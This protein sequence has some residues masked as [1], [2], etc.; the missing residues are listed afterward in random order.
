M[1][2]GTLSPEEVARLKEARGYDIRI[3]E[4]A[5]RRRMAPATGSASRAPDSVKPPHYLPALGHHAQVLEHINPYA[6]AAIASKEG[7]LPPD[8]PSRRPS[9]SEAPELKKPKLEPDEDMPENP[10]TPGH[11]ISGST[12]V[13]SVDADVDIPALEQAASPSFASQAKDVP[14]VAGFGRLTTPQQVF[15]LVIGCRGQG[16]P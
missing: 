5:E 11:A 10:V 1:S 3:E 7:A 2:K 13:D 14:E 15:D 9:H 6:A 12:Q 16:F 4:A 8:K